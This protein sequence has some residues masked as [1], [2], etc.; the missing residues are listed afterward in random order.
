MYPPLAKVNYRLLPKVFR[1]VKI[2]GLSLGM[3]WIIGP[4]LMFFLSVLFLRDYPEYMAGVIMIGLA[5]CIAMVLVWNDL[6]NGDAESGAG[7]VAFNSIFQ[8]LTYSFFA[9]IFIPV[10]PPSFGIEAQDIN[11]SMGH[12]AVSVLI[13]LGV[14]F[15]SR[16]SVAAAVGS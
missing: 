6:A 3:N 14:P 4:F 2:V 15:C 5:R 13:Y 7:L 1:N 9:Y 11:I 10:L 16:F 12:V 8:V